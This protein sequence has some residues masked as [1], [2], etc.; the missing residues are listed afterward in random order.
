MDFFYHNT[1]KTQ[2]F[3]SFIS[4]KI[5]FLQAYFSNQGSIPIKIKGMAGVL[6]P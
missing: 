4:G 5:P 1:I 6:R 3:H 2:N